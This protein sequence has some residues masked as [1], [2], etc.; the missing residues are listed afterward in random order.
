M[1]SVIIDGV[2]YTYGLFLVR[3]QEYFESSFAKTA[4]IG[5]LV[6]GLYL[7]LGPFTSAL[8]TEYGI[9]PIAMIG[10]FFCS[11]WIFYMHLFSK[12]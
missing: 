8:A 4:L 3:L 9:R 6:P 11:L 2:C 7:M 12:Y 10:T 5:S 1:I